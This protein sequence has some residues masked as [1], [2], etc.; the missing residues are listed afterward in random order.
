LF[1][2]LSVAG[3][4][5]LRR[6]RPELERPVRVRLYPLVPLLYLAGALSVMGALLRWRPS[7]TWPG[8]ALV[9]LG[10]PFYALFRRRR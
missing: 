5:V 2:A 10:V 8:L 7:F 9:A 1:Y 3:V 4:M 6:R